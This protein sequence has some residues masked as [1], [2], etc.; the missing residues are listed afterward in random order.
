MI[1]THQIT[2]QSRQRLLRETR[3]CLSDFAYYD[4]DRF[5]LLE[6]TNKLST[7][8]HRAKGYLTYRQWVETNATYRALKIE[9]LEH[10]DRIMQI[11]RRHTKNKH[12]IV[13]V[14]AF[15]TNA[16]GVSFKWHTDTL[17]VI[18]FNLSGCKYVSMSS[19]IIKLLPGQAVFIPAGTM[20]RVMSK[21]GSVALSIGVK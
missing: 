1:D 20:H 9:G 6:Q 17:S 5:I 15:I 10:N 12:Q 16:T 21:K 13:D 18:L 19:K 3:Q 8:N 7:R 11:L 14:H 2:S 4:D